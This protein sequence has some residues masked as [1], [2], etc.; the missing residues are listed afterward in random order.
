MLRRRRCPRRRPQ[1]PRCRR[2]QQRQPRHRQ[3]CLALLASQR[4]PAV[5]DAPRVGGGHKGPVC[6]CCLD[7][8]QDSAPLVGRRRRD[9]AGRPQLALD[10]KMFVLTAAAHHRRNL[11]ARGSHTTNQTK[12]MSRYQTRECRHPIHLSIPFVH[13]CR[14]SGRRCTPFDVYIYMDV[15]A[16]VYIDTGILLFLLAPKK[17][18]LWHVL[19]YLPLLLPLLLCAMLIY[20]H[21]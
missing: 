8:L 21:M 15:R 19:L 5:E 13:L 2:R 1:Q 12:N 16:H 20:N 10:N 9:L 6:S 18:Y 4:R 3:A 11:V 14:C 7:G 17:L